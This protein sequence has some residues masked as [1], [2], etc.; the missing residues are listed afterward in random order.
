MTR[1]ILLNS[2]SRLI[3]DSD[4]IA[5]RFL[6]ALAEVFWAVLL[7]LPESAIE[8]VS[9]DSLITVLRAEIWAAIFLGS[10]AVQMTIILKGKF[11]TKDARVFAGWNACLWTFVVSAMLFSGSPPTAAMAGDVALAIAAIWVFIRPYLLAEGLYRAG[12]GRN[13]TKAF[14]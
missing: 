13:K 12:F 8:R 3:W 10:A 7:I 6:L 1:V 2:I 5:A 4:L 14:I 11:H 9:Y